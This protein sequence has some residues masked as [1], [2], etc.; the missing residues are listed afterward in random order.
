MCDYGI[1]K[2][3]EVTILKSLAHSGHKFK[4]KAQIDACISSIVSA[5]DSAGII[6]R[7]SCCGHNKGNG[8]ILLA[9]DRILVIKHSQETRE[10]N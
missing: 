3:I 6:M 2:T 5:L 8:E 1:T 10:D 9:D 4:K 7:G